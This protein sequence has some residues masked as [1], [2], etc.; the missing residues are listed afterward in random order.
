MTEQQLSRGCWNSRAVTRR[1]LGGRRL[2]EE[3]R[4]AFDD[5]QVVVAARARNRLMS[6]L[7]REGRP[8]F[9]VKQ[10]RLPP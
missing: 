7:Q 5:F 6:A 1:A 9:V 10:G 8:R 2:V 4:L 3:H